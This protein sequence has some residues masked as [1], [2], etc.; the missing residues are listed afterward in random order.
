MNSEEKHQLFESWLDQGEVFIQLDSRRPGVIV[1]ESCS[2][3][4][5]LTL[6]M[7][8]AFNHLPVADKEKV[9]CTLKFGPSYFD[10]SLPWDAIWAMSLDTGDTA[11]SRQQLWHQDMPSEAASAF[12]R[13]LLKEAGGKLRDKLRLTKKPSEPVAIKSNTSK[14]SMDKES[15][16]TVSQSQK[17]RSPHLKRIK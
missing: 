2:D 8:V 17:K 9:E 10:C 13:Q 6:R 1:P 16:K 12:A 5:S 4:H 14:K 15:K 7:S 11:T 3:N